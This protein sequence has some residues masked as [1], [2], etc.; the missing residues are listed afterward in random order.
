[1][2]DYHLLPAVWVRSIKKSI[3]LSV[4]QPIK[5]GKTLQRQRKRSDYMRFKLNYILS[6]HL[7]HTVLHGKY[8]EFDTKHSQE[9]FSVW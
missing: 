5:E 9:I 4:P 1:M 7:N 6:S 8:W 2:F 3:I